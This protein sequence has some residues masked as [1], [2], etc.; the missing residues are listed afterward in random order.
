MLLE[1][2]SCGEYTLQFSGDSYTR[3]MSA[4]SVKHFDLPSLQREFELKK[5][6]LT[7]SS[8]S[9]KQQAI[10]TSNSRQRRTDTNFYVASQNMNQ[11]D[12]SLNTSLTK[13]KVRPINDEAKIK[14]Q[15]IESELL[16]SKKIIKEYKE[17]TENQAQELKNEDRKSVV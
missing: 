3:Q 11:G 6:Q 12:D 5:K 8:R 1:F 10:G 17:I 2:R 7:E 4:N 15:N 16:K 9:A 14:M 13:F